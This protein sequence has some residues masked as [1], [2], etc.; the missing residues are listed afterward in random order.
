MKD[1]NA[2]EKA[3]NEKVS[4][5][6]RDIVDRFTDDIKKISDKYGGKIF[7][8]FKESSYNEGKH[9]SVDGVAKVNGVL[10]RMLMDNHGE[11]MLNHKSKEL[12]NKLDL[13]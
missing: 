7:Y 12:I 4:R 5:E 2:I 1:T 3:L 6:L 13:I 11:K 8:D 10:H 9:F